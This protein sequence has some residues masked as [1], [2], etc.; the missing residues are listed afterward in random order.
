MSQ[1]KKRHARTRTAPAGG[2]SSK[3]PR[4][5]SPGARGAGSGPPGRAARRRALRREAPVVLGL[6]LD[7]HDFTAMTGYRTF[8]HDDYAQYL[9]QVDRMLRDL[10]GKGTHVVV[11]LFDPAGYADYC[12][13]TRQPPDIPATRTRYVAESTTA[14]PAVR[15]AR[16]PIDTVR[17]DLAREAERRA[18]WERATDLLLEAGP[19]PDC[20]ED[21]AHCAFDRASH[22]LLRL[23]EALGP[24]SHHVVCSL[25]LDPGEPALHAAAQID[26][27]PPRARARTA[28]P[29]GG[30]AA[31]TRADRGTGAGIGRDGPADS[32]DDGGTGHG[33]FPRGGRDPGDD[34]DLRFSDA[35]MLVVCTVMTAAEVT[36]RTAGL[37]IRTTTGRRDAPG[38]ETVR[39]WSLR[40]GTPHPLS[41]AEVFNAY[42]TDPATGE[43]VPPEPGVRYRAGLP[44]P[45]PLPGDLI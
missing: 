34:G 41:E 14:G 25:R 28:T 42:C 35:D 15:Y 12:A 6:L 3:A 27:A 23:I 36:R 2:G 19:C 4:T 18:T 40:G 33:G 16:Q 8:P 5:T 9:H 39:G 43:P 32:R 7:D 11:T 30:R 37:V 17:A 24:G 1:A 26:V 20:D 44:L 29:S 13:T 10:H 31:D 21:L 22:T 38:T 45:P